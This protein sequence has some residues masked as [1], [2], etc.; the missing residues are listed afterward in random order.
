MSEAIDN[1]A[2]AEA[3]LAHQAIRMHIDSCTRAHEASNRLLRDIQAH[4]RKQADDHSRAMERIHSRIDETH[5]RINSMI[6]GT[7]GVFVTLILSIVTGVVIWALTK[8][9]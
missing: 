7:L 6:R 2:R 4:I 9:V 1:E 8:G 5:T 3:R